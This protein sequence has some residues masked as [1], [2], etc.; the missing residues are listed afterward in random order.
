MSGAATIAKVKVASANVPVPRPA[1]R[2]S[3][4]HPGGLD[5]S[6]LRRGESTAGG[7]CGAGCDD[8][9]TGPPPPRATAGN[10]RTEARSAHGRS[11]TIDMVEQVLFERVHHDVVRRFTF[12]G[13]EAARRHHPLSRNS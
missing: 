2:P 7:C 9:L 4:K 3:R 1:R 8:S 13:K 10:S 11:G 5:S 12:V 6:A